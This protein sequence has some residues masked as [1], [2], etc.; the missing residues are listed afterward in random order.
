MAERRTSA[1][2]I[3][4]Q[5]PRTLLDQVDGW[6][7]TQGTMTRSGAIQRL[8]RTGL[9]LTETSAK[10][11]ASNRSTE[12]A[13]GMAGEMIDYLGDPSA[14]AEDRQHRKTRLLKGP[15][16][17]RTMRAAHSAKGKKEGQTR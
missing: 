5:L 14:S 4:I 15:S 10:A 6:A 1:V 13:A 9:G 12:R 8:L 11:N 3:R 16:E 17:F 2:A 7:A